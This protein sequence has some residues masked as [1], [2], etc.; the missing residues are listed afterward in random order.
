MKDYA[1]KSYL[2]QTDWPEALGHAFKII[3]TLAF[4]LVFSTWYDGLE[5][6]RNNEHQLIRCLNY[7][8][9]QM[10]VVDEVWR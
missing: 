3:A 7:Q 10:V 9:A 6:A 4:V 5:A 2:R 1:D 8:P